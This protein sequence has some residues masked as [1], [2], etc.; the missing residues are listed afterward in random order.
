MNHLKRPAALFALLL[1][2][3]TFA[4]PHPPAA[5]QPG[6][7][8]IPADDPRFVM[9][10]DSVEITR[11][12]ANIASESQVFVTYGTPEDAIGPADAN[13][14]EPYPVVSLGDGGSAV[15]T[16]PSPIADIPG[17]DFAVFENGFIENFLE[18]AHVEVSSDGLSYFRFP[19]TSLTPASENLGEGGAVDPTHIRNLAGKYLAGFGTPFD[20]AELSHHRPLLDIH[21]VTHV[22]IID[23]VGTN[24]PAFASNDSNGNPV[25]DPYP[26][27]FFSG[28]FDL[29]A[30]GA[31]STSSSTFAAWA[32]ARELGGGD[33]LP[34][35]DP[36]QNGVPN[37]IEYLT[38]SGKLA[39]GYHAGVATLEFDRL[40][41]RGG[42]GLRVEASIDFVD[43]VPIAESV[44]SGSM[45]AIGSGVTVQETGD[46]LKAVTV[47]LPLPPTPVFYRLRAELVPEP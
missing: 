29:D 18:L 9:W 23:V 42:A 14:D 24:D 34:G 46:F 11:G 33:A 12:P 36:D 27:N 32:D 2:S 26:T 1:P 35:A 8:A 38:G 17:P 22:R 6:S 44:D 43:W 3:I 5:G 7:D 40:A 25:I 19:S 41:Y 30:V 20:L 16:F 39:P 28:G 47:S 4:G 31:F 37:L 15:L 13:P 21:R 10:A 45:T